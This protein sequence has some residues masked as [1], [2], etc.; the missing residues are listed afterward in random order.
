MTKTAIM[1]KKDEAFLAALM[2]LPFDVC[3][4]ERMQFC[5]RH[6]RK[7][8]A[9]LYGFHR[10]MGLLRYDALLLEWVAPCKPTIAQRWKKF[11]EK[12]YVI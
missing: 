6:Q 11:K 7:G 3:E 1:V 2:R 12:N 4:L 10:G 8:H 9:T 5:L